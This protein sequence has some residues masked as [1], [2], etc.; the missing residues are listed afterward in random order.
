MFEGSDHNKLE[1][2]GSD[3]MSSEDDD[4]E[5]LYYSPLEK[6]DD[7]ERPPFRRSDTV[8]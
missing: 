8:E 1:S 6:D 5:G 2:E 7:L 4:D 3:E